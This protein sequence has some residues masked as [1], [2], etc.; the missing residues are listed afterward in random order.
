MLIHK[1]TWS[2]TPHLGEDLAFAMAV[3]GLQFLSYSDML[4]GCLT[5]GVGG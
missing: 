4:E 5:P 2:L 3:G 1:A